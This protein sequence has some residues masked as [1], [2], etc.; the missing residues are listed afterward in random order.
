MTLLSVEIPKAKFPNVSADKVEKLKAMLK[1]VI[2]TWNLNISLDRLLAMFELVDKEKEAAQNLKMSVPEIIVVK[3]PAVL[4]TIDGAPQLGKVEDSDLM[5]VM[6]TPYFIVLDMKTKKY[7]LKCG[8]IWLASRN[9]AGPWLSEQSPPVSVVIAAAKIPEPGQ[10]GTEPAD[11]RIPQIIVSTTPAE[12]I[13]IDGEPRY[14]MIGGTDL[15]YIGNTE[16]DV[17]MHI[18]TQ[19]NFVLLSGRWFA[20]RKLDGPWSYVAADKLPTTF[21]QIPP[22]SAKGHVLASVAGTLQ[23]KEAMF[24]TYIPQTATIK[25]SEAKVVVVYDGS[26]TFVKIEGTDMYYSPNTSF[27]VIRYGSKYYCC[28]DAVWFVADSP[29]GPW[30]V[31]VAVP[32]VI[33]TIP[34]SCPVYHVKY[35]R[36]YSY[37]PTVVYVG[38]TPGYIGCY[39][40]G[41][42]VVY[43]TGYVY[44]G[45]YHVHYYPR[46]VTWG[47]AVR[48]NPYTGGWAVRVSPAR[49][50]LRSAARYEFWDH[51]RDDRFHTQRNINVNINR[52]VYAGRGGV[53]G[54]GGRAD[55][56]GV[57]DPRGARDPR[58]V[59]DPHGV[60]DPRGARDP[61]G[62]AD[63]RGARDPRGVADPRGPAD[64]RSSGRANNVFAD[65]SGNVHRKTDS[66]WQQKTGSGWSGS[67][68]ST[69]S[70][71]RQNSARERGTSRT[72]SYQRSGSSSS[73]RSGRSRR[74]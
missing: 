58:G 55:P 59:A 60:A 27:S 68:S 66:G 2:P 36:V 28:N 70:L 57:A 14:I 22:N 35:V 29:S 44:P 32:Q 61:R 72:Q 52:N 19:L 1:M 11:K 12:L 8:T 73:S 33:Y 3:K 46:P 17:F 38:Y 49:R 16:S 69:S 65:S 15:L 74:R 21:A 23:A 31:C 48:Y 45:W 41:T 4:V 53:P 62:V 64:P 67:K 26:P 39:R 7:Y 30:A 34:A 9:I 40:Y 37:T 25:R 10:Q 24:D 6:N 13:A 56:R 20:S 47:V 18:G 43:G 5:R 63:P 42:V 71:E 50:L 51:R 54:P